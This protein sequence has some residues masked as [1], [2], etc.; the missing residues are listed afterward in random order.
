MKT[1]I[2]YPIILFKQPY[3]YYKLFTGELE[4]LASEGYG[5]LERRGVNGCRRDMF[6]KSSPSTLRADDPCWDIC[7]ANLD[8]YTLKFNDYS[9]TSP[10]DYALLPRHP[11]YVDLPLP[12]TPSS[13]GS[14]PDSQISTVESTQDVSSQARQ[15]SSS[16]T[17]SEGIVE[18]A[19]NNS[20]PSTS[21]SPTTPQTSLLS[22]SKTNR[23]D[24]SSFRM[25]N[26]LKPSTS[27]VA[28]ETVKQSTKNDE[29]LREKSISPNFEIDPLMVSPETTQKSPS[30]LNSSII[31]ESQSA[32]SIP[33]LRIASLDLSPIQYKGLSK[34]RFHND[35]AHFDIDFNTTTATPKEGNTQEVMNKETEQESDSDSPIPSYQPRS[36]THKATPPLTQGSTSSGNLPAT[37]KVN[38]NDYGS[39]YKYF[40][41]SYFKV[42][43]R[44]EHGVTGPARGN[45]AKKSAT[46]PKPK[47][48][49]TI[50]TK[51]AI[52]KEGSNVHVI[53]KDIEIT[54]NLDLEK[55]FM[56]VVVEKEKPHGACTEKVNIVNNEAGV[57]ETSD[58]DLEKSFMITNNDKE[59]EKEKNPQNIEMSESVEA[60]QAS[61][62]MTSSQYRN[63]L[64]G[65]G[66][67]RKSISTTDSNAKSVSKKQ[68]VIPCS[69][70][71]RSRNICMKVRNAL[72]K[73]K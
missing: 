72:I 7:H 64:R 9:T 67:K 18:N 20:S 69:S 3:Y 39:P 10:H 73:K 47:M 50:V 45:V 29:P 27:K 68:K 4:R 14:L 22:Q 49:E 19:K 26:L 32:Q 43:K 71:S 21:N 56:E 63:K 65:R 59:N 38:R 28:T 60:A 54:T 5:K 16:S 41:D 2:F 70:N 53:E 15:H 40:P 55:S 36:E 8:V 35:E 61:P 37:L 31:E 57:Q 52:E 44:R 66:D 34:E 1:C 25:S 30:L 24:R 11:Q 12:D 17:N 6:Y 48:H 23:S 58:E 62:P 13:M 33:K 46:H 42:A 51:T